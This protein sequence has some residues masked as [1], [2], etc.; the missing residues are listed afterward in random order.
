M[1]VY[2]DRNPDFRFSGKGSNITKTCTLYTDFSQV[3]K[4]ENLQQK[5]LDNFLIFA[6]NIDCGYR[7][8]PPHRGSSNEYPQSMFMFLSKNKNHRYTCIPQFCYIK[9][10]YKGV[11]KSQTCFPDVY[12]YPYLF[13]PVEQ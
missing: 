10:G 11:Y 12:V 2:R 3:V 4:I 8:E 6:Q 5:S 9:V 13:M 7:L 1:A